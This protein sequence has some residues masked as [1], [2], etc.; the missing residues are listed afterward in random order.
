[1][2]NE[3]KVITADTR[4]DMKASSI[5]PCAPMANTP[6]QLKIPEKNP[7]G[8]EFSLSTPTKFP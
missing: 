5:P 1:L 2:Y 8:G 6:E 7:A 4:A 3:K